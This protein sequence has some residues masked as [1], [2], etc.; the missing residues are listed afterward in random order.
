MHP[1]WANGVFWLIWAVTASVGPIVFVVSLIDGSGAWW[2]GLLL[3][4]VALVTM[5]VDW[6][7]VRRRQEQV[8]GWRPWEPAKPGRR[9]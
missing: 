4:A 7:V 1:P 3:Y 6:L 8:P 9:T 2:I 5:A